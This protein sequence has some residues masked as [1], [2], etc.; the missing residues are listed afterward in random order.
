MSAVHSV[1]KGL[2]QVLGGDLKALLMR[3]VGGLRLVQNGVVL[4]LRA[5]KV[6]VDPPNVL[7]KLATGFDCGWERWSEVGEKQ[8]HRLDDPSKPLVIDGVKLTA[9]EAREHVTD[10]GQLLEHGGADGSEVVDRNERHFFD[11]VHGGSAGVDEGE[12]LAG[13]GGYS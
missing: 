1:T 11:E 2:G 4:G 8:G 7:G 9:D 10:T 12:V 13:E 3:C 6:V 5:L